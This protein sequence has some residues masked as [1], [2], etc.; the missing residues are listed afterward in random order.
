MKITIDTK[1]DSH[2]DIYKV[3][4]ILRH[5]VQKGP[6]GHIQR[7][8]GDSPTAE[9]ADTTDLMSMFAN[10][11]QANSSETSPSPPAMSDNAPD[12]NAFLNLT[13]KEEEKKEP[14][15]EFF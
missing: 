10:P 8:F 14:K 1:E 12:F 2:E 9:P 3:M 15:I 13:N 5:V 6:G 11:E 4:Q 7:G